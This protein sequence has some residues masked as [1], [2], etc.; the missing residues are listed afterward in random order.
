MGTHRGLEVTET[1]I[2]LIDDPS[3]P[4]LK[5]FVSVVFNGCYKTSNIRIVQV[6]MRFIVSFPSRKWKDGSYH[7]VAHPLDDKTRRWLETPILT[8][9]ASECRYAA[10]EAKPDDFQLREAI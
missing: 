7:D 2:K 9:Y 3:H 4:G 8:A 5:A 10:A 6:G 1:Q